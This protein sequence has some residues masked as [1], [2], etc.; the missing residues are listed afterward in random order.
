MLVIANVSGLLLVHT[1]TLPGDNSFGKKL[2][3]ER[4]IAL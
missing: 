2:D 1:G 4:T 3:L